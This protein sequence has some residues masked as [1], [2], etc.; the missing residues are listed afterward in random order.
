MVLAQSERLPTGIPKEF[1]DLVSPLDGEGA[2]RRPTTEGEFYVDFYVD[3]TRR[4]DIL[5]SIS[6]HKLTFDDPTRVADLIDGLRNRDK[7]VQRLNRSLTL[8]G[9]S[10][11]LVTEDTSCTPPVL[12]RFGILVDTENQRLDLYRSAE[13]RIP[14]PP[15]APTHPKQFGLITSLNARL[16]GTASDGGSQTNGSLSFESIAGRGPDSLFVTGFANQDGDVSFFR[17]GAQ[18]F[19][20][21]YR[22]AGGFFLSESSEFFSQLDLIG[23]EIHTTDLTQDLQATTVDSPVVLFLSRPSYV[24][25]FRGGQLLYSDFLEAGPARIPTSRFPS[26]SY[27]VQINIRDESGEER[28][29]QRFF[30]RTSAVRQWSFSVQGGVT[31][32][33]NTN[34]FGDGDEGVIYGAVRAGRP[35][36]LRE[37]ISARVGVLDR[38][39]FLESSVN[40]FQGPLFWEVT[41]LATSKGGYGGVANVS[42]SYRNINLNARGR[43]SFLDEQRHPFRQFILG[44]NTDA[45]VNVSAPVPLVGGWLS[46]FGRYA[47]RDNL[48]SGTSYGITWNRSVPLWDRATRG[49]LTLGYQGTGREKRIELR[50]RIS[51]TRGRSTLSGTVGARRQLSGN[52][53]GTEAVQQGRWILRSKPRARHPWSVGARINNS[54]GTDPIIGVDGN[55]AAARVIADARIDHTF[56]PDRRTNYFGSAATT[57]AVTPKKLDMA[58]VRIAEGGVMIDLDGN[59]SD[60]QVQL[61]IDGRSRDLDRKVTFVPLPQ[62]RR[63]A[64][65]F[66]PESGGALGYDAGTLQVITFPGNIVGL[67]PRFLRLVSLF[68]RVVDENGSPVANMRLNVAGDRHQTDEAGY[69]I[70]DAPAGVSAF[71]GT[72]GGSTICTIN[73][74]DLEPKRDEQFVDLGDLSCRRP[75]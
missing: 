9:K 59:D 53:R 47:K 69:F 51:L 32:E 28:Q 43:H 25:V 11:C 36:G 2:D 31:R 56:S 1:L 61:T 65:R 54:T 27:E 6:E 29:E 49:Q 48:R 66:R 39:G 44:R 18:T 17:A 22:A 34:R 73:L 21:R 62:F 15:L 4:G 46:G 42:G 52:R 75:D 70:L 45:T 30:S 38:V 35:I 40:G 50:F 13:F 72:A 41:G 20:G 26:G 7:F 55:V 19:R 67:N 57:L 5:V 12:G 24:D 71:E 33:R 63:H 68:G 16:A 64:L 37:L 3:G 10:A 14:P 8:N 58:G 23:G 74:P 60:R